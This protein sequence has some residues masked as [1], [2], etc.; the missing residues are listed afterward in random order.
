MVLNSDFI[1]LSIKAQNTESNTV[2]Q[3][4]GGRALHSNIQGLS[5]LRRESRAD[6]RYQSSSGVW[7]G[8]YS[9]SDGAISTLSDII[10]RQLKKTTDISD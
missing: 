1:H 10:R 4:C 7:V 5:E 9:Q 6:Q 8:G 3:D 2:K